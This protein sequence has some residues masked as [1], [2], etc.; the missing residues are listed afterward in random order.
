MNRLL[1]ILT[2]SM[3]ACDLSTEDE[4]QVFSSTIK[5]P[6]VV[7]KEED[8]RL[9]MMTNGTILLDSTEFSGYLITRYPNDS[10]K[11]RKGYYQGEM[12]GDFV[13]YYPN[14]Q[15]FSRRPYHL[16]EKHGQ[17]LGY[18][19]DGQLKFQYYFENGFGQRTHLEWYADGS[20][21]KEMNYVDGK[22]RGAQ[23]F[24]RRDGKYRS[25]YVVRENGRKYGMLGLK[26]CA[27][28]DSESGDIDPY[29]GTIK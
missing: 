29:K 28:I 6:E 1:L 7:L 20:K 12:E 23:K 18:Y 10:I 21:K 9:S 13:T 22:E 11:S 25:N 5:I 14:G 19:E 8:Q 24:W 26:R 4:L 3:M 17:H 27:K 15:V 16:G 2:L